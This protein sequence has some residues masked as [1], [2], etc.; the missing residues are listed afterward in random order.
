MNKSETLAY[1]AGFIDGEGSITATGERDIQVT[2]QV[3]NKNRDVLVFLKAEFGVGT[4][5]EDPRY[6]GIYNWIVTR[7]ALFDVLGLLMPYLRVKRRQAS[8]ALELQYRITSN[9]A[10][11]PLDAEERDLRRSMVTQLHALNAR[12]PR[13]MGRGASNAGGEA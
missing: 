1:A 13:G 8:V 11:E 9:Y 6:D 2:L 12:I 4:I 5:R 10:H 3:Y 7:R